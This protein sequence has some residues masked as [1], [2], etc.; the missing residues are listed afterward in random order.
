M[1]LSG[2]ATFTDGSH[3]EYGATGYVV[4]WKKGTTWK[5]HKTIW[6][7]ARRHTTQSALRLRGLSGQQQPGTTPSEQSPSSRTRRRPSGE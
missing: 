7:G 6:A 1:D 5:G 2:L 3:L 4:T